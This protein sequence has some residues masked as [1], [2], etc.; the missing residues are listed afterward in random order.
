LGT[1]DR[2][3]ATNAVHHVDAWTDT[4]WPESWHDREGIGFTEEMWDS[5]ESNWG[6]AAEAIKGIPKRHL[7]R[8][9]A[10]GYWKQQREA[11]RQ[12][13]E[14]ELLAFRKERNELGIEPSD[15][16][17]RLEK[18]EKAGIWVQETNLKKKIEEEK[19][20]IEAEQEKLQQRVRNVQEKRKGW[21]QDEWFVGEN[22]KTEAEAKK[23]LDMRES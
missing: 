13:F 21:I 8:T 17:V 4:P 1:L 9:K 6:K 18:S 15:R 5:I 20:W 12:G 11:W 14:Q 7:E 16:L 2:T 3:I 22:Q 19:R 10:P 23:K